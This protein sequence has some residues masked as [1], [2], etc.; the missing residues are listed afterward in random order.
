VTLKRENVPIDDRVITG[1]VYN[2][3]GSS[4][5]KSDDHPMTKNIQ[6]K[7]INDG[8]DVNKIEGSDGGDTIE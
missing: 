8:A 7:A 4:I 3:L 1:F 6:E 5:R 2:R